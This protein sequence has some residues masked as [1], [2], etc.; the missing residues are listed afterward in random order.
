MRHEYPPTTLLLGGGRSIDY[1]D[2]LPA[3]IDFD[4]I[5]NRLATIRRFTG[6][7]R[8]LMVDAHSWL[9]AEAV[10]RDGYPA[11]V[12]LMALLHD[13]HEAF[14]GDLTPA[15]RRALYQLAGRDV[16]TAIQHRF[17]VAIFTRAGIPSKVFG[18]A[19]MEL[20]V[21]SYDLRS[22]ANELRERMGEDPANWRSCNHEPLP[23]TIPLGD[24]ADASGAFRAR[25]RHLL[26]TVE[27]EAA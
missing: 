15:F 17:D 22:R 21:R 25:L 3:D 2:P 5:C 4:F 27:K 1:L 8:A 14:T 24:D 9:V 12:Q 20:I 11:A 16:V 10:R 13:A 7:P 18:S 23:F 6:H 26:L 19:E